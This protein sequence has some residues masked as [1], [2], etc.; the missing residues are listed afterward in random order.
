MVKHSFARIWRLVAYKIRQAEGTEVHPYGEYAIGALAYDEHG[1][2]SVQIMKPD[3]PI[4]ASGDVRYGSPDE[5]RAAFDGYL[6]YFGT[7][8]FDEKDASVTHHIT[9]SLFPDWVGQDRTMFFEFTGNRLTLK[10]PPIPTS[11]AEVIWVWERE[12]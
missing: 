1:H 5:V 10:S 12:D 4:F 6:A 2:M 7:Y 9:G 3:R 11:D 8:E